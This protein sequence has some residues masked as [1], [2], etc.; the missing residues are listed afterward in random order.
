MYFSVFPFWIHVLG[1][2]HG[3]INEKKLAKI[4]VIGVKCKAKEGSFK[5]AGIGK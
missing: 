5:L 4:D 1:F 2:P 3:W